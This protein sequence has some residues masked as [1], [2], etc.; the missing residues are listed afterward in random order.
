[1]AKANGAQII[2]GP[3]KM[4]GHGEWKKG[5]TTSS[6]MEIGD[7]TLR[8]VT[9]NDEIGTAITNKPVAITLVWRNSLT[10]VMTTDGKIYGETSENV[11]FWGELI[12]LL[13]LGF[14]A[15]LTGIGI[16]LLPFAIW[17]GVSNGRAAAAA[18]REFKATVAAATT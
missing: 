13:L 2:K 16:V 14:V 11:A 5:R 3:I 8:D 17:V 18:V 4:I 15:S 7:Q 10:C 9:Y 1:M 12:V 6:I